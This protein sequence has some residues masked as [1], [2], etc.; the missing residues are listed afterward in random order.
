MRSFTEDHIIQISISLNHIGMGVASGQ[1]TTMLC[2]LTRPVRCALLMCQ[3][4]GGNSAFVHP[5]ATCRV[6]STSAL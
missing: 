5:E 4:N 3:L 2:G 6:A 1:K